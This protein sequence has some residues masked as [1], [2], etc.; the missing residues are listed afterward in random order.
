MT[1]E[2]FRSQRHVCLNN[3]KRIYTLVQKSIRAEGETMTSSELNCRLEILET[4]FKQ[5]LII[6]NNIENLDMDDDGRMDIENMYVST[7]TLI[8]SRL[9][10]GIQNSTVIDTS[11]LLQSHSAKL[12]KLK[13]PSFHGNYS[14][15]KNFFSSFCQL[16]DSEASLSNIEKFNHLLNSLQGQ[17]LDTVK[18]FQVTNENYPKA[19]ARLKARYDNKTLIFLDNITSLFELPSIQSPNSS[20]LRSLVDNASALYGSLLSLG[21]E[22]QISQAMLIYLVMEKADGQTKKKWS[23]SLDFKQLPTWETCASVLERHCQFLESLQPSQNSSKEHSSPND[24][25]TKISKHRQSG[26][27]FTISKSSCQLCSSESHKINYCP[28]FRS[29]EVQNRFDCAKKFNLCL[30]C[31]SKGHMATECPSKFRCRSCSQPH[32][33]MLH[34]N[35]Q[36]YQHSTNNNT[37]FAATNSHQPNLNSCQSGSA[38]THTHIENS[39]PNQVILAT[40]MILVRDS[41]GGYQ[42]GRAL[43]DSCSQVNFITDR[44]AQSLRLVRKKQHVEVHG[45]GDSSTNIK[46]CADA[47]IRSR[48]TEF[49]LPL[50]FCITSNIAYQPDAEIEI[51]SWNVPRNI[52]LAD[53]RFFKARPVDILLGTEGFFDI[54]AVGQIKLGP[55]LPTLQKTLLGWVVTGRCGSSPQIKAP[56]C[57]FTSEEPKIDQQLERF[58]K[59]EEII[60][61]PTLT[62][63]QLLCEQL[64]N[65]TVKRT[66]EGRVMVKLPFK[67]DQCCLGSSYETARRRFL[68]QERR[69]QQSN[70]LKN[71]YVSFMQ[72]YKMLGHMS[73]VKNPN[74]K[75]S[76]YYI[77][78]HCVLRPSSTSTKL[79]VVFDASCKSSSQSSLNDNLLVGPVLQPELYNLLLRFRTFEF[80][81]TADIVKMYRQVLIAPEDRRYQYILWRDSPSDEIE[82]YEL[83]TVTYGTASAPYLA[84]RSL[85]YLADI[86]SSEF[87]IGAQVIKNSFYVDDLLCGGNSIEELANIKY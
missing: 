45:I 61:G 65:K 22:A 83:N 16:I 84:V 6:Q 55:N 25:L 63:E 1:L 67:D 3:M 44:F 9:N 73:V 81:L 43:L 28:R 66:P 48:V 46:H 30:N 27:S 78:H 76:H 77:P 21:S 35:Q 14:E 40:A 8:Q 12:P 42:L 19:L 60:D 87:P 33:S 56:K 39:S 52:E 36:P 32:H 34:K 31:L 11:S 80:A 13:L 58:W 10:V 37:S 26:S 69:N 53:D 41:S 85:N 23:E 20:K 15:F 5:C 50:S 2:T 72:E 70:E 18:A 71:Q 68:A 82:T 17:A 57:L 59:I 62:P 79:R 64:F 75:E 38:V 29:M 7:K 74:L 49:E 4:Y 54:L 24:K 47:T 86:Y 51:S